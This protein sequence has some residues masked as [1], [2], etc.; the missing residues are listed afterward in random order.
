[1]E[2]T[3]Y[4]RI[5]LNPPPYIH[6]AK[7]AEARNYRTQY[8]GKA[9]LL[10]DL[11]YLQTGSICIENS[12]FVWEEGCLGCFFHDR[13]M[14]HTSPD[15]VLQKL[16]L[17]LSASEPPVP[18]T[19]EEVVRWQPQTSEALLPVRLTDPAVCKK[20]ARIIERIAAQRGSTDPAHFL[21]NR[22]CFSELMVLLMEAGIDQARSCIRSTNHERKYCDLACAYISDHLRERIRAQDVAS[23]AGISYNYL[24]KLFPRH[25]GMRLAE[26][27]NREK[28]R[29]VERLLADG[30]K[31]QT[32]LA[33]AVSVEDI[34]YFR[35]LFRRYSG[36]T[37]TQY[38]N[39]LKKKGL[40]NA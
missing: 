25:L 38:R 7:A 24:S 32:E 8:S 12:D 23:Y 39:S 29:Y 11:M 27:I 40:A 31:N 37:I 36:M 10:F 4:Y 26:Y 35:R 3:A 21:K 16:F 28:V 9:P 34:K 22:M 30:V 33:D 1:M 2:M 5:R 17:R 18:M 6:M 19:A 20:A 14:A 13:T 15:P